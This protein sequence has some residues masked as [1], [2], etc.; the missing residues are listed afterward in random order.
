MGDNLS[1]G[2]NLMISEA[3]QIM[4]GMEQGIKGLIAS[5][6]RLIQQEIDSYV[7]RTLDTTKDEFLNAT[8]VYWDKGALVVEI[9][10][11]NWLAN[12]L[13]TGVDGWDMKTT[14]LNSPKAKFSRD[15]FRY[16][17]IPIEKFPSSRGGGTDKSQMYHKAINE[18]LV[19]P[20]YA[21]PTIKMSIDGTIGT[22]ERLNTSNPLLGGFYRISK[23]K[24]QTAF[25]KKQ[26][27]STQF[28]MFRTMSNKP[29]QADK[30]IHP[31]IR[32]IGMFDH[33]DQ[34]IQG[35]YPMI[36]ENFL[37][38]YIQQALD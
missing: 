35:Q 36:A 11:D 26:K 8:D 30:W 14:H 29:S 19:N 9:D 33:I 34:W 28:I 21:S 22:M 38:V 13:E 17:V 10:D 18:A 2:L 15:G 25:N 32:G 1:E 5:T 7:S 4:Q 6:P 37:D 23:Y 31:G 20:V 24:D 27:Q 3:L 12:A 16:L